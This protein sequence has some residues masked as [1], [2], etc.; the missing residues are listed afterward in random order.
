MGVFSWL[1]RRRLLEAKQLGW[2]FWTPPETGPI[3]ILSWMEGWERVMRHSRIA[4][5]VLLFPTSPISTAEEAE[6]REDGQSHETLKSSSQGPPTSYNSSLCHRRSR[7]LRDWAESWDIQ[8]FLTSPPTSHNSNLC[9][10]RNEQWPVVWL[11][12]WA[13]SGQSSPVLY[14]WSW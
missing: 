7:R 8:A 1:C 3:N 14:R 10:R 12:Q 4:H 2:A 13:A 6:G 11:L 5:K 9:H